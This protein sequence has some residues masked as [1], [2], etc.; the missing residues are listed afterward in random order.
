MSTSKFAEV[1]NMVV[2]LSKPTESEGFVQIIDFLNAHSIKYALTVNP[3][4]YTS[5]IKQFWATAKTNV[6]TEFVVDDAVNEEMDDRLVRAA[7]TIY[8]LE[9]EHDIINN[10][11]TQSMATPNESSSQ[12][13]DSSGGPRGQDTMGEII[14][15]TRRVKKLEKKQRSITY[16]LKR[17][18]KVGLSARVESSDD[19]EGLGKEDASKQGRIFDDLDADED[20]TLVNDQEIFNADKDLQGKEVVVEQEVVAYKEQIVDAVQVSAAVTTITVND[21]TLAK[22]VKALKTLKPK[23]RGIVIKDHEQPS[24]LRTT[25]IS[26]NNS[27]EKG[28]AKIIEEHV[29]LKNKDQILFDEVARKLQEE[30]YEEERL[31]KAL[32]NKSFAEIQELFDKAMKRKNTFVDFKT[33]FVEESSKKVQAEIT[34]KESSKRAGDKL[35]QETAK[36]QKIVNDKETTNLKQLVKIIPEEDIAIDDIPLVV[37]TV[38]VDWKIYKERKK[39]YYQIIRAGGKSKN[40]IVFS[41]MLK[42]F[43]RE[44]V[45]TFWKLVKA[46]YGSTRLEKDYDRVLWGDLKVMFDPHVED[47][48]WKNTI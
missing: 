10:S 43:D 36:K 47:E 1:H 14:A 25:T 29:K 32:K 20:I 30:I 7:T 42:D 5:C 17:L 41:Y 45:E 39:C 27:Q 11:K 16:K 26:L 23:I 48:V 44:D 9:A 34:Q 15:Q 8:S 31:P 40:Y 21:I 19:N 3:T 2:F 13:T 22:A 33:E 4:I 24:E 46:K 18:Y 28:K 6:P 38:I 35:E 37:K 12:R